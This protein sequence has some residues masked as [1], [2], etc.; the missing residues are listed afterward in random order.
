MRSMKL[1]NDA[2]FIKKLEKD[3][4]WSDKDIVDMNKLKKSNS[5]A[6]LFPR[7]FAGSFDKTFWLILVFTISWSNWKY[8]ERGAH[9]AHLHRD[10]TFHKESRTS[11]NITPLSIFIA[12]T[13]GM[14]LVT[15]LSV[16]YQENLYENGTK[17]CVST[18]L[19]GFVIFY[20]YNMAYDRMRSM[21]MIEK[22]KETYA[23][24]RGHKQRRR[25]RMRLQAEKLDF[26]VKMTEKIQRN[27]FAL[28]HGSSGS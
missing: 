23:A 4:G 17:L 25:E 24:E 12:S 10:G 19:I 26:Q 9:K 22:I 11:T 8:T 27:M 16:Y 28:Q 5:V 18:I 3:G 2:E 20:C 14:L 6:E 1:F 15:T 21:H 7:A 13:V